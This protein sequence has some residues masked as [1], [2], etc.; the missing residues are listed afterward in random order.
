MRKRV[1]TCEQNLR[2]R[3]QVKAFENAFVQAK[4]KLD[5]V[6]TCVTGFTRVL[7]EL[8]VRNRDYVCV[9]GFTRA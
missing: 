3:A 4:P 5:G 6:F 7:P 2:V 9:T 8:C 1:Y